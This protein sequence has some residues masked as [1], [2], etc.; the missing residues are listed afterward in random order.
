MEAIERLTKRGQIKFE[1]EFN[2]QKYVRYQTGKHSNYFFST[3]RKKKRLHV[4]IW[5]FYNGPIPK[6]KI[7][8]HID[9]NPLNNKIENFML[10]SRTEHAKI[11]PNLKGLKPVQSYSKENWQ[12]RRAGV[13]E[14][15]K[16]EKRGCKYCGL[17]F[18]PTNTHQRFCTK[19]CH[20]KWQYKSPECDELRVCQN[21]GKTFKGNKYLK[22]K[23]CSTKCAHILSGNNRPPHYKRV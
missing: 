1:C 13:I 6:G 22:P 14:K 21:C 12:Q 18:T 9:K 16:N 3:A 15:L 2:G 8:H 23:T 11:H 7:I 10:V 5:E 19:K 17:S 4:A 20:H